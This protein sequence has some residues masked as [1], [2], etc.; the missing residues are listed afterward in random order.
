MSK[1]NILF[2]SSEAAPYAKTG[3]L[4]DV[5]A[6]LPKYLQKEGANVKLVLPLYSCIDRNRFGL[7]KVYDGCCVQMGNCEEW[8]SL[9]YARSPE[10]YDVFFIEF[11]KYFD[12][13]VWSQHGLYNWWDTHSD[14][15]DNAYRYAFFCRAALQASKDLFFQPDI[16]HVHDWQTS[17]IP[18]YLKKD[19]DP[20]FAKTKSILTIH[21]L[22]YQGIY[23]ADVVPYAK[24]DWADFNMQSFED[25]GRINLLKGGIRYAD[26]ITTVSPHYAKEILTPLGG[27]GLHWLLNERKNDLSGILNGIDLDLWNPSKDPRVAYPYNVRTAETGKAQNKKILRERFGLWNDNSPVFSMVV[28]LTEQKGIR[29]FT[30]CI[31]GVMN[32]MNCQFA[33]MGNGEGWAQD[34]LSSLTRRYPGRFTAHIGFDADLEHVIDAGSDFT[35]VPSLYE[36]CGLKQ[37][38]SQIYGTLP[39]VRSTG[40]LADTVQNYNEYDGSGT[41]F[42]F[43]DISS[44]ALYN[45]I[46]W[47]NSTYYDRPYH[48]EKLVKNAMSQNFSWNNSAQKYLELYHQVK[49]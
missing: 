15:Q 25:Y 44:S 2:V 8:Y 24:I 32:T 39:I 5:A 48:M 9:Y 4:G 7:K 10:G 14:Y 16:V 41:G 42:K 37:M 43:Y 1:V 47:A 33:V 31:E 20:F 6:A 19:N 26:K 40:G 30:E 22:P 11:N 34:Y 49:G 36:P 27:A 45:T 18:Y 23:G 21:N 38:Y 3:G 35:L 46:G 29:M 17:L 12:R 28:R 13:K